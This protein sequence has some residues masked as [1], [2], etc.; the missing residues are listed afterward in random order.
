MLAA[1][2]AV[3]AEYGYAQTTVSLVLDRARVSRRTFYEQFVDK[4]A[5]LLAAYDE[6]ERRVWERGEAAARTAADWSGQVRA[7]M[8]AT[9][10]FVAAESATAHLFTLEARAA[11]AVI[12]ERHRVALARLAAILRNG[13]RAP[14]D[15][16][17]LPQRT[18]R[19]LVD[20]VAALVGAH[21]LSGVTE[22]LPGYAPQLSDH[23]L[24]PYR[25]GRA[26][27]PSRISAAATR[28]PR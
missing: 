3:F 10:E 7:A 9:L 4:D 20:Q 26:S 28:G 12:A 15:R 27:V 1:V 24:S 22:L 21:V 8:T 19:V 2:T 17:D 25:E 18:E 6:A 13:N 16:S 14:P 11:S 5:C 23:L